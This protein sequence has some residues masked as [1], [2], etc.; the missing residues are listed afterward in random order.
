LSQEQFAKRAGL[1]ESTVSKWEKEEQ[2][3]TKKK[4][5]SVKKILHSLE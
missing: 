4:W 1:D 2:K 3:S 5:D